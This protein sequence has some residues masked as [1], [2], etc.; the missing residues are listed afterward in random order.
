MQLILSLLHD[1]LHNPLIGLTEEQMD[2]IHTEFI[3]GLPDFLR[4]CIAPDIMK[5][6]T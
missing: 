1:I 2:M 6:I 4:F 5:Q 3:L